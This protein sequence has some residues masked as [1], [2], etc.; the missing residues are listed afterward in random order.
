MEEEI[1]I[2]SSTEKETELVQVHST[3]LKA[4][5]KKLGQKLTALQVYPTPFLKD[6]FI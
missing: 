6:R 5:K 2:G 3:D 4:Q 1:G